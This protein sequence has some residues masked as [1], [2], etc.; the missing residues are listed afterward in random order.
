ME[1]T[2][3]LWII[4]GLAF[5]ILIMV[6]VMRDLC[7]DKT[8][9][10]Q[11]AIQRDDALQAEKAYTAKLNE[12]ITNRAL[13][14]GQLRADIEEL[15]D[16]IK[17][18]DADLA[19]QGEMI[20]A[21]IADRQDAVK[22]REDYRATILHQRDEIH[23]LVASLGASRAELGTLAKNYSNMQ[24]AFGDVHRALGIS[25]IDD[26]VAAVEILKQGNVDRDVLLDIHQ[27]LGVTWG[28]N[29]YLAIDKLKQAKRD[30]DAL[31]NANKKA[32]KKGAA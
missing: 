3:F 10:R 11:L 8:K 26:A 27:A 2:L 19:K 5:A 30:L 13:I 4:T 6:G 24:K 21:S 15:H 7:N 12:E 17:V 28:D 1:N 9:H 20:N 14:I 29:V 16:Y 32:A 31:K 25:W 23:R 22:T 18:K